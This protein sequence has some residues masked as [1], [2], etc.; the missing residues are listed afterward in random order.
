MTII[1]GT[2]INLCA[3]FAKG[4]EEEEHGQIGQEINQHHCHKQATAMKMNETT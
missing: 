2:I 3:Y 4:D 1:A